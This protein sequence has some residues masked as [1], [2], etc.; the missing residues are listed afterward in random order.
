MVANWPNWEVNPLKF[1]FHLNLNHANILSEE[2]KDFPLIIGVV[3]FIN[4]Y[5][6]ASDT[7]SQVLHE[8]VDFESFLDVVLKRVFLQSVNDFVD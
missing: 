8:N 1:S 5:C 6:A 7:K 3:F 4:V 2:F